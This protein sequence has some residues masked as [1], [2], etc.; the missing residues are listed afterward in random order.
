MQQDF[1]G[2]CRS[3]HAKTLRRDTSVKRWSV[4]LPDDGMAVESRRSL[5]WMRPVAALLVLIIGMCGITITDRA[6]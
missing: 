4:E 1:V 2:R 6:A 3:P 5:R